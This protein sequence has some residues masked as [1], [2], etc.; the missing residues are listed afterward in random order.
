MIYSSLCLRCLIQ[1]TDMPEEK[2]Q[3]S[4]EAVM[5]YTLWR[6]IIHIK[7]NNLVNNRRA[8]NSEDFKKWNMWLVGKAANSH[9]ITKNRYR[10]LET[11]V[12]YLI[13]NCCNFTFYVTLKSS[14]LQTRD[15]AKVPGQHSN[16]RDDMNCFPFSL[17]FSLHH[18]VELSCTNILSPRES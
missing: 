15:S 7:I 14:V 11:E 8:P 4:S 5:K 12:T 2:C 9:A 18:S 13:F 3:T 6:C 16:S 17:L 1:E 10:V